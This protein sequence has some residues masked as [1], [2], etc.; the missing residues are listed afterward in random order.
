MVQ[1]AHARLLA[2]LG[3]H[4]TVPFVFK[5][6][7]VGELGNATENKLEV[8]ER[9][10]PA[11]RSTLAT[12]RG[13]QVLLATTNSDSARRFQFS[14]SPVHGFGTVYTSDLMPGRYG[15]RTVQTI[16]R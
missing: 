3:V 12:G 15:T 10:F 11:F 7:E 2:S 16:F 1:K 4:L 13:G 6:L 14:L 9:P 5:V 8:G